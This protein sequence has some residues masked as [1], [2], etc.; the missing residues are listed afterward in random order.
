MIVYAV[1]Q[2]AIDT[3]TGERRGT[4]TYWTAD[5]AKAEADVDKAPGRSCRSVPL[6]EAPERVARNLA[7]AAGVDYD[8]LKKAAG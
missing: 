6:L 1:S 3:K 4:M 2:A 8:A 5:K 7:R